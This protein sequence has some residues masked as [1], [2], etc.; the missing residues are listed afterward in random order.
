MKKVS[1]FEVMQAMS[2]RDLDIRVAPLGNV[3][4]LKK[5]KA[6]TEVTIG[7]SGDMVGSIYSG[8]YVGGLFLC[9]KDEYESIKQ[10]LA[11]PP[12]RKE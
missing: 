8:K 3:V 4:N 11:S 10:E 7:V 1:T 9:N 12:A 5:V 6:G 2:D